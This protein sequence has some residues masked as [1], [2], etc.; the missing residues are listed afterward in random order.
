MSGP[1]HVGEREGL[2]SNVEDRR[3]L[4]E[5]NTFSEDSGNVGHQSVHDRIEQHIAEPS[6]C[7]S[8]ELFDAIP[9]AAVNFWYAG[10]GS[11]PESNFGRHDA[12]ERK[13]ASD[14]ISGITP[15]LSAEAD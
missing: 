10:T 1:L 3:N 9:R 7:C 5:H 8:F 4:G 13:A 12:N 6:N 11:E 14:L 2:H 15:R